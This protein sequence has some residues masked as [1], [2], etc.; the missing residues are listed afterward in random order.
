MRNVKVLASLLVVSLIANAYLLVTRSSGPAERAGS[1]PPVASVRGEPRA[2]LPPSSRPAPASSGTASE[3]EV[4]ER[5]AA[6]TGQLLRSQAELE[7]HRPLA[8]RFKQ[9]ADRSPEIEQQIKPTLDK[10]FPTRP[11]E[12]PVYSVEC[13]GFVCALEVDD[14][15]DV[16]AWMRALQGGTRDVFRRFNFGIAGTFLEV[17]SPEYIEGLRYAQSVLDAIKSSPGVAEC[18]QRFHTPGRVVLSV[19]LAEGRQVR[20][21]MEG[22]LAGKDLGACLRPIV[23]RA[24][25]QVPPL[26]ASIASIPRAVLI[27]AVEK[28]IEPPVQRRGGDKHL[29]KTEAPLRE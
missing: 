23:E 17:G 15:Q 16:D 5:E 4:R 18:K 11:G 7:E 3:P 25:S 28:P 8:E 22:E 12:K 9:S 1:T 6:L 21:A 19:V 29:A 14:S 2:V 27:V 24:P 10:V 20:V 26:P 13:H